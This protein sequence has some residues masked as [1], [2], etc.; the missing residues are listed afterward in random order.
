MKSKISLSRESLL[1]LEL[2]IQTVGNTIDSVICTLQQVAPENQ[3]LIT[4]LN[5]M[6]PSN[7]SSSMADTLRVFDKKIK[8]FKQV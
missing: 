6:S 2:D 5:R 3:E 1:S 8:Q 7:P 4:K